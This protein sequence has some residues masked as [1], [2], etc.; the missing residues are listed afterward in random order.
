MIFGERNE[1]RIFDFKLTLSWLKMFQGNEK[2]Q[3][4]NCPHWY[5]PAYDYKV[6]IACWIIW[7]IRFLWCSGSIFLEDI[8]KY[9]YCI[10]EVRIYEARYRIKLM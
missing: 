2:D 3:N 4:C 7:N 10:L 5:I 6:K 9:E 1:K 8:V